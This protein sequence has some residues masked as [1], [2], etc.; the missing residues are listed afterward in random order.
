MRWQSLKL[1]NMLEVLLLSL[2]TLAEPI[3][4]IPGGWVPVLWGAVLTPG[5]IVFVPDFSEL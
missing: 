2:H 3:C 4:G 1:L 5:N